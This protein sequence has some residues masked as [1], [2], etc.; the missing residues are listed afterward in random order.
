MIFKVKQENRVVGVTWLEAGVFLQRSPANG[1][2]IKTWHFFINPAF[3]RI[4]TSYL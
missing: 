4:K 3:S 1:S 2:I